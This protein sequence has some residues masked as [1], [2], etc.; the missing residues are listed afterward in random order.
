M[1]ILLQDWFHN[2]LISIRL[3]LRCHADNQNRATVPVT[4]GNEK[5]SSV[6]NV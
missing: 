6:E 1:M 3:I 2:K 4:K 5:W